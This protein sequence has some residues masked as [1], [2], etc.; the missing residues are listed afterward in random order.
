MK[1]GVYQVYLAVKWEMLRVPY[2]LV[3]LAPAMVLPQAIRQE[4]DA[5]FGPGYWVAYGLCM[6]GANVFFSLG[7][8]SEA[9]LFAFWGKRAYA[10]SLVLFSL[11]S[12]FSFLWMG[13][14]EVIWGLG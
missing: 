3:L 4:V 7:P 12:T 6:L 13:G 5:H 8:L 1:A 9:Y 2:N 10:G 11:G 14:W